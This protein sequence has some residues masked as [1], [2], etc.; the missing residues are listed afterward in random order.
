MDANRD[1]LRE[2]LDAL[3]GA[4]DDQLDGSSVAS[5]AFLSRFH[6]DRVVAD[7]LGEPPAALR[8]RL[9]LERA[10]W[11]IAHGS[12]IT[13]AAWA[14][15]Y[16]SV[17]GFSRAFRRLHA[18][19]PSRFAVE[20]QDFR[21]RAPNGV[22]FLPPD[23]ITVRARGARAGGG[24]MVFM[25]EHDER[26]TSAL[27]DAAAVLT[28][29]QLDREVRPGHTVLAFDGPE[30]TVRLMVDRLVWTKEVWT[31]AIGG[32]TAPDAGGQAVAE[33]RVRHD[34]AGPRFTALVADLDRAGRWDD[35]FIDTL[36]D[37]PQAF[38]H[39]AVVAHVLGFSAHRREVLAGALRDLGVAGV[40]PTC[41]IEGE[42]LAAAP[43]PLGAD[44]LRGADAMP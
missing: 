23:K 41:P 25:V 6:F 20:E 24:P 32:F 37:P 4:L 33:L 21:V 5:R 1:R 2:L 38:S 31:A 26:V 3:I 30:P 28:D 12:S 11:Q 36:C 42:R 9:L 19:A 27:I 35:S 40:P 16:E 8:R 18:V 14:A 34:V 39:R 7:G 13:E 43:A 44:A 10:A 29:A 22:H 15:G 17:E